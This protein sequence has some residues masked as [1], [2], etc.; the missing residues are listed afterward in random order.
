MGS[1][2]EKEILDIVEEVKNNFV[3]GMIKGNPYSEASAYG[4][5][6]FADVL[7]SIIPNRIFMKGE[8]KNGH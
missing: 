7:K 5:E 6:M 2:T 4:I 1:M 3:K 8:Q